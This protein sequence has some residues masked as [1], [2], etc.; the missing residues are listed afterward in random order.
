MHDD[1]HSAWGDAPPPLLRRPLVRGTITLLVVVSFVM[2]TLMSTCA[3]PTR[4]IGTTTTTLDGITA[5][6]H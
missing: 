6:G 2:L 1:H 3:P 4:Q 5:L